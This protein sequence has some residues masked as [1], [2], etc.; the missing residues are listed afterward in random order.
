MFTFNEFGDNTLDYYARAA[1]PVAPVTGHWLGTDSSGRDI[2]ARLLYG[3]RVS[4]LFG[5]ALTLADTILGVLIGGVQ[6]Y[7]G[8]RIDLG[9]QRLIEIWNSIPALYC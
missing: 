7:F 3:F 5:I 4:I 8:G 6:G 9:T 1:D 2:V